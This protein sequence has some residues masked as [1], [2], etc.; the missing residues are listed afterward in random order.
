MSLNILIVEDL[1]YDAELMAL[2]LR[3]EGFDL[4]YTRVQ[5]E[6]AYLEALEKSPDLILCDWHL[7]QF[8]GQ[9]ALSLL[10]QQNLDIPF[11]IV[12]GGIG[13]EAAV[14]ALRQGA[15]DYVLKDR[16][17]R[18]GEA[19]R[20]VLIDKQLRM[21]HRTAEEKLRLADR[22]FQNTAEGITVTDASGNIVSTNPAFEAITGYSHEEVLGLNPRVLKSG[23]HPDSFYKEMW[24]TLLLT[25]HW[26][27]EIWNRRKNGDAYP[28]WLTISAVKDGNDETTHYVGV[29]T[30]ISQIKEAQDQI[31][32][33]AHHDALTRLPNRALFRER[34]DHALMHARRENAS[35]ALLFLDLDRFKTV[36]DTLGHPVGD[37]VLL[38]VSKRMN[39]IIRASDTLARLGGDEFVL[40]LEE[41]TDAQ[42]AAVVARKLID[43]F[44]RP[45]IIGEHELV[46]TASIGI[47]LYPND[48][49]DPDKLI[50]HADR[51]MY[52]AKQQGRNT[53]RFFTQALTEGALERLMME[54]D[55]R[56]AV[57][58]NELILHYQPIVNLETRQ[59]QGIE[60]LVRW[61][62]PEQGLI[63]P[64]LFIEL[65]EE[66]GI[67]G[68]IGQW[69]LRAACSQLARWDR[70]GFKVPR[71]SV[72]LSVQQIDREGLITMVSEELNSSGLSPERLE[73]EVTESMLIRNPELSR[74]V[75][76]ELRT[77]G[78][79]FAI[80]DFGTGYSSL[81][82]LKLLPLDH[83][84]IDQSFVRDIGKDANDEAIV[85][86]IIGMS[87]SLGLESVAEGV[88]EAHQ[89]RF[90]QQAGSDLAQGYLYSR[91]LPADEIFSNWIRTENTETI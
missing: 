74:T 22:A 42:H 51:A 14:D 35:I 1:P 13:E 25:G 2:R 68:E 9:R 21:A 58:R 77:L 64:G 89:A 75:L 85:R 12:S 11:I 53:Y 39:L 76:S 60:A 49:D 40:L 36:N 65:A 54:N 55:L 26:R 69:V 70:D 83:L 82:Y 38:E 24:D 33:L 6:S 66:I 16:P 80:D 52:E 50:R 10:R 46:V 91:P 19:V 8:S 44:S 90:L 61:Q 7:P 56:R 30:D 87:K 32:F 34:F 27:G 62:H 41:Q 23:H 15:N 63:A 73:L 29:F 28:E 84:K 3:D 78:V 59:L 86:A 81:A 79:K 47:T 5:R 17:A 45:M 72:N 48:G 20:R 43:L 4:D 31:N 88:E 37:Q 67:I 71:I 18:L 57:A